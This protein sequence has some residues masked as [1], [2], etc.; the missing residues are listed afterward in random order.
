MI[1]PVELPVPFRMQPGLQALAAGAV[2]LHR[3][4]PE[5]ALWRERTQLACRVLLEHPQDT[6][7]AARQTLHTHALANGLPAPSPDSPHFWEEMSLA[8]EE[9]FAVLNAAT[10]VVHL[11]QVCNPSRWAP[12]EKIG[13]HFSAIHAPVAD[14]QAIHRATPALLKLLTD[15]R[16]WRRTVWTL[17]PHHQ[18]DLHPVRCQNMPWPSL[19]TPDWTTRVN[20]RVEEQHFLPVCDSPEV[21]FTIR[22]MLEPLQTW[23]N[24]HPLGGARLRESLASMSAPVQAYKG[25]AEVMPELL[26]ALH[27]WQQTCAQ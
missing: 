22:V 5:S 15:G 4:A 7:R 18:Y 17:T 11:L 21:V 24:R 6:D 8:F 1:D 23:L 10:G 14:A 19:D 27:P 12:E 13:L 2:V 26:T 20:L 25:L 16:I 3:L 9:D